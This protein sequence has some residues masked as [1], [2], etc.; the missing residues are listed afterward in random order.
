MPGKW[1]LQPR[2]AKGQWTRGFISPSNPT[3]APTTRAS[4]PLPPPKKLP[5]ARAGALDLDLFIEAT[6]KFGDEV[7]MWTLDTQKDFALKL[8]EEVIGRT[9]FLTGRARANWQLSLEVVGTTSIPGPPFPEPMVAIYKVVDQVHKLGRNF[10][11]F[12]NVAYIGDL[13]SGSSAKAPQGIVGPAL[14]A[15]SAEMGGYIDALDVATSIDELD[16]EI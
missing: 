5:P 3:V 8:A 13:E 14:A 11:L 15:V 4:S 10:I 6:N 7:E 16:E 12:N 1:R 9:P 2:N